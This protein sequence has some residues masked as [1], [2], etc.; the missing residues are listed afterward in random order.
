V[1]GD[2]ATPQNG[3]MKAEA[4][5]IQVVLVKAWDS[6]YL[7]YLSRID[8]TYLA[9]KAVVRNTIEFSGNYGI[10]LR[11]QKLRHYC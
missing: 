4:Q 3:N 9:E 6:S 8:E 10:G 7:R 1:R 5:L 2:I 11:V